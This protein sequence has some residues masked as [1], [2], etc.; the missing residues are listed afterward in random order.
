MRTQSPPALNVA[1]ATLAL[2]IAMAAIHL[3][4]TVALPPG[5]DEM[6]VLHLGFIPAFYVEPGEGLRLPSEGAAWLAPLTYQFLHGD[7]THL[8]MNGLFLL[9]FGTGVE[10]RIGAARMLALFLLSGVLALVGTCLLF[11]LRGEFVLLIGAS[12]GVS[13]LFGAI[14][15]GGVSLRALPVAGRVPLSPRA[16]L[17]LSFVAINLIFG[18]TGLDTFGGYR[19]IAW[20]AHLAGFFAGYLMYPALRPRPA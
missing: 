18:L 3:L 8:A 20:E 16:I 17:V 10:H 6:L 15:R 13:G 5:L 2:L 4:R 19:A 11:F 1:P 14:A 12:G 9:A 7:I